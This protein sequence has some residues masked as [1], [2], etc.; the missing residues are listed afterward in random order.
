MDLLQTLT[1]LVQEPQEIIDQVISYIPRPFLP[2]FL[3]FE[4]LV[5]Y[6]LPILSTKVR[7]QYGYY[8]L[9]SPVC[10]FDPA[11][12]TSPP[13]FDL[14]KDLVEV[15]NKFEF[16]PREIEL[17]DALIPK[18]TKRNLEHLKLLVNHQIDNAVSDLRNWASQ[19]E[20]VFRQFELIHLSDRFM[21]TD[22]SD[23]KF[24]IERGFKIGSVRC[25]TREVDAFIEMCPATVENFMVPFYTFT[26]SDAFQKFKNLKTLEVDKSDLSM[27]RFLPETIEALMIGQLNTTVGFDLH[28]T[29][30][31][32]KLWSLEVG[33]K[34]AG[35]FS[36]AVK[37]FPKLE[38]FHLQNSK[39]TDLSDL[40]LP[41]GLKILKV[42]SCPGLKDYLVLREFPRLRFLALFNVPFPSKESGSFE[43][44]PALTQF[45]FIQS[46]DFKGGDVYDLDPVKFPDSLRTLELRGNFLI[47]EWSPPPK[48]RELVL[49]G[50]Q[51]PNGLNFLL[52]EN[53][54]KLGLVQTTLKRLDNV[55]FPLGLRD[56][57]V[58][59]NKDLESMVNTNLGDLTQLVSAII[60]ANPKLC[61]DKFNENLRSGA[62]QVGGNAEP[63]FATE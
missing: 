38:M 62:A 25:L 42:A 20:D 52:P 47:Q 9:D 28:K 33:I 39:V 49:R 3:D 21:D 30:V 63:L 45:V 44:C 56:L 53:L 23:F 14:M 32:P 22:I 4:P 55:Q 59:E 54:I 26:P 58:R 10:S 5:P 15:M 51:F 35:H 1:T 24:C 57:D 17:V 8:D 2:V 60:Y 29:P 13:V 46:F 48:L 16:C 43:H 11:S 7:I 34:S 6:I 50:A 18:T 27:F 61:H 40:G 31:L 41:S 36:E 19:Y 12:Y 37:K